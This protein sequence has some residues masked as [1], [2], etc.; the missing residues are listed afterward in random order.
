VYG[1]TIE[2]GTSIAITEKT[3]DAL[4]KGHFIL[5]FSCKGFLK[6]LT[7]KGFRLP[8]FIDYSYDQVTDDDLRFEVYCQELDRLM[9]LPL[10]DWKQL[11]KDHYDSVI[12]YNQNLF[13]TKPYDVL[14]FNSM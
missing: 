4:I 9:H 6:F 8:G 1:E 5:P 3:Y 7:S 10:D 12:K 2:T 11:W 14:N 13:F